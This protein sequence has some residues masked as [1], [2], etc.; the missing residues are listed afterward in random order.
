MWLLDDPY[1]LVTPTTWPN[2]DSLDDLAARPWIDGLSD[3]TGARVLE[4]LRRSSGLPLVGVHSCLEFPAVLS[5][6]AA[7][8]GAALVPDLALTDECPA[9]VRILDLPRLGARSI[10]ATRLEKAPRP[11]VGALVEALTSAA[12]L[13][14]SPQAPPRARP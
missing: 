4:R 10:S 1:R 2:P 6:V 13:H 14:G 5:L 11:V 9:G 8:M 7:G 12:R 3:S